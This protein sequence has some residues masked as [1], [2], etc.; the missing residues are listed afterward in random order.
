MLGVA[1]WGHVCLASR[2]GVWWIGVWMVRAF[3]L[4]GWA[5]LS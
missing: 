4:V 2:V 1:G 5:R 3:V